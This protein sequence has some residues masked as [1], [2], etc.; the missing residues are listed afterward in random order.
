MNKLR[1]NACIGFCMS[2]AQWGQPLTFTGKYTDGYPEIIAYNGS[3]FCGITNQT[4]QDI[5][6]AKT[7]NIASR[8]V[9]RIRNFLFKNP[10]DIEINKYVRPDES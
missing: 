5:E 4:V 3:N 9:V 2:H 6:V 1:D 10:E 7:I 8:G